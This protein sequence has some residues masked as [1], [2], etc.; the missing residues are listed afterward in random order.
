MARRAGQTPFTL[1]A[2]NAE[3]AGRNSQIRG[4]AHSQSQDSLSRD[5]RLSP[6]QAPYGVIGS[7]RPASGLSRR[8]SSIPFGPPPPHPMA[9][10]ASIPPHAQHQ[11]Q[12]QQQQPPPPP[13][14]GDYTY[15]LGPG[16]PPIQHQ[17]QPRVPGPLPGV[18]ELTTGITP[19]STPPPAHL[20][21]PSPPHPQNMHPGMP[22]QHA[23]QQQGGH[24][25]S[26]QDHRQLKRP[27]SPDRRSHESSY[28]RR[29][30]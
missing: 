16:L 27:G 13:P 17:P 18:A 7:S 12:H 30:E 20:S 22:Q 14:P 10:P 23:N 4:H 29:M 8:D 21:G 5:L 28:R 15:K 6:P 1:A 19:Y 9:N 3:A 26:E 24:I 25:Y 11:H 2:V